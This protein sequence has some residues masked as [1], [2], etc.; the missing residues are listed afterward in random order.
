MSRALLM[1][2]QLGLRSLAFPAL[3]TGSARVSLE[4][5]ANAMMT[6]LRFHVALGGSRL[7]RVTVVLGDER[8]L[9]IFHDVAEEA[10]RGHDET[11]RMI[12]LGLAVEGGEV[13][14]DA[15]TQLDTSG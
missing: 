15:A 12:D 4:T 1:A 7:Q 9:R 5:S 13:R 11:V 14:E 6:A 2:D 10:L 8:K 3:G